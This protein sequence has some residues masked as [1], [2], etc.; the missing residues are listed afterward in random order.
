MTDQG[1]IEK[2]RKAFSKRDTTLSAAQPVSNQPQPQVRMNQD[3]TVSMTPAD[4]EFMI[5]R[6]VGEAVNKA[7]PERAALAQIADPE[8]REFVEFQRTNPKADKTFMQFTKHI[9]DN[10]DTKKVQLQ[11][12]EKGLG[13]GRPFLPGRRIEGKEAEQYQPDRG[14]STPIDANAQNRS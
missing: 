10:Y 11:V 2:L 4:L 5:S 13:M 9:L 6:A 7:L 1:D 8:L 3:G 12:G 14:D